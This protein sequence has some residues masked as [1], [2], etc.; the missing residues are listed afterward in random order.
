MQHITRQKRALLLLHRLH[1]HSTSSETAVDENEAI[2][3][4]LN[5]CGRT[6]LLVITRLEIF[7]TVTEHVQSMQRTTV[8]LTGR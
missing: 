3:V 7:L 6:Q 5:A 8:R 2:I 1:F 4:E